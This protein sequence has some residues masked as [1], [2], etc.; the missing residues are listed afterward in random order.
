MTDDVKSELDDEDSVNIC[1][2]T[3]LRTSNM[4]VNMVADDPRW[5]SA[6]AVVKA[7]MR[8]ALDVYNQNIDSETIIHQYFNTVPRT[9]SNRRWRSTN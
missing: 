6:V 2:T 5:K 8:P 1:A 4:D 3:S 9:L 7:G